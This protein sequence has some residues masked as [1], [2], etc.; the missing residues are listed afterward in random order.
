MKTGMERR[1]SWWKL[2]GNKEKEFIKKEKKN[3]CGMLR[4]I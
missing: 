2:I 4:K 3:L 1:I